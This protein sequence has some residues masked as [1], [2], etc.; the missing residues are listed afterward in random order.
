VEA[1]LRDIEGV[2]YNM[3]NGSNLQVGEFLG[4][5][6]S[7]KP[8]FPTALGLPGT[9]ANTTQGFVIG[10]AAVGLVLIGVGVYFWVR[11]RD[12]DAGWDDVDE[13]AADLPLSSDPDDLIDAIITL[14][15]LYQAGEIP[16]TAYQ[17]RRAVLKNRLKELLER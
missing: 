5:Q 4:M 7:G 13:T 16:E 17:E 9:D 2:S 11:N 15:D 8:N 3:Y 1:G 10:L 12:Q 6:V 14:D